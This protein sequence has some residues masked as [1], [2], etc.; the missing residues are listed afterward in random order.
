MKYLL[1]YENLTKSDLKFNLICNIGRKHH[2]STTI[3][4][5]WG[6]LL[7]FWRVMGLYI[8]LYVNVTVGINKIKSFDQGSFNLVRNACLI[9]L[10]LR[11]LKNRRKVCCIF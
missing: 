5:N 4:P 2:Y 8:Y 7:E 11:L 1:F 9:E 3:F 6:C 10:L